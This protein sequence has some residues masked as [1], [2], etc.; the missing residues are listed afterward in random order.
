M[1]IKKLVQEFGQCCPRLAESLPHW[2]K[3]FNAEFR[4]VMSV[5]KNGVLTMQVGHVALAKGAIFA[6]KPLAE[7]QTFVMTDPVLFCPFCGAHLQ[8]NLDDA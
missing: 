1:R 3:S 5:D 4:A 8:E 2:E 7:P 6:G